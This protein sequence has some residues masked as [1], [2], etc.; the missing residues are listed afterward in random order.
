[1][2]EG[3]IV[4]IRLVARYDAGATG[5]VAVDVSLDDRNT[6]MTADR[7]YEIDIS[8]ESTG[9]IDVSDLVTSKVALKWTLT[10]VAKLYSTVF[11]RYSI[12]REKLR[13]YESS[14]VDFAN[15]LRLNDQLTEA[16]NR[17]ADP[18]YIN[19]LVGQIDGITMRYGWGR[20]KSKSDAPEA[21]A[22]GLS[23]GNYGD[24][25]DRVMGSRLSGGAAAFL[26]D[27]SV[28]EVRSDGTIRRAT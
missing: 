1:L 17:G 15:M 24:A 3:D 22:G 12:P 2:E 11:E 18:T 26:T 10:D 16:I 7:G 20:K 8:G 19:A 25:E 6:W 9:Y 4:F 23:Y 13:K 5:S 27:K 28:I 21:A 14:I